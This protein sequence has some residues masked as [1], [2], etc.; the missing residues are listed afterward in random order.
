[1]EQIGAVQAQIDILEPEVSALQKVRDEQIVN[2]IAKPIENVYNFVG[3]M[4]D[5]GLTKIGEKTIEV[6]NTVGLGF[7][8]Q[9]R[10]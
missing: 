8:E 1:M 7:D 4:V 10:S 6:V 9:E 3:N 2:Q 5:S